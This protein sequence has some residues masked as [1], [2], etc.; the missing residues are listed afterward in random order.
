MENDKNNQFEEIE[1]E[2]KSI[3]NKCRL[4]YIMA[5]L[6]VAIGI[7]TFFIIPFLV[8]IFILIAIV[9]IV[10]TSSKVNQFKKKFK[11][12]VVKKM[13]KEELGSEAVYKM[14]GG[15]SIKEINSLKIAQSPDRSYTEDYISCTYN[16]V[17]Y[18][19]CDCTLE[20]RVETHDSDGHTHVSYQ[21]YFKGR[22]IKIDFKRDLKMELKVVNKPARGFQYRPLVPFQ[23]EVIEF[24]KCFKCYASSEEDGFYILTP[25]LIQKMLEL[26]KMYKG[27]IYYV[28][29]KGNLYV[30]INNSGDSLEI[31]LSKP[32]E[33]KQLNRIKSDILI[34]ASIINEFRMD[35]DK[36]NVD[37]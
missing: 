2:R 9:I 4:G 17:F 6:L 26:E 28:F 25:M 31:S 14:K 36:Y 18:E 11:E 5:F 24:N 13:V 33:E 32:L 15:I 37:R 22:V 1:K 10:V 35:S 16:G 21:A 8:I 29:M 34:G 23:T 12:I 7:A 27:G 20:E 19:M 30:L 3:Y